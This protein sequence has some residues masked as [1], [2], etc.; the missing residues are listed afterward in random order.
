M[1][2]ANKK[3]T[4]I[5]KIKYQFEDIVLLDIEINNKRYNYEVAGLIA[6]KFEWMLKKKIGFKALNY[7][8]ENNKK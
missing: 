4:I 8:K 5:S 2:N 1:T 3:I 6:N 7:L